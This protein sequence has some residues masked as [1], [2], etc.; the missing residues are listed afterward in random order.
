MI[1]YI[2]IH[3]LD[4]I[5]I[6]LP[7]N[8]HYEKIKAKWEDSAVLLRKVGNE[9][10]CSR[11]RKFMCL[12]E[13]TGREDLEGRKSGID[14]REK[15]DVVNHGRKEFIWK[16]SSQER[17]LKFREKKDRRS[18]SCPAKGVLGELDG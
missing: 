13:K 8:E 6:V 10:I 9:Y 18:S 1:R 15:G 17:G 7:L 5:I 16:A 11:C 2:M 4:V 14:L 3:Q 12:R